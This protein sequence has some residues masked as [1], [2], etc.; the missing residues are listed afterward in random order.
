MRVLSASSLGALTS[1]ALLLTTGL[2]AAAATSAHATTGTATTG[3]AALG[4]AGAPGAPDR[5]PR[6]PGAGSTQSLP[7]TSLTPSDRGPRTGADGALGLAPRTVKPFSLLGVVWED[8]DA[9]LTG[10]VQVRTRTAGTDRWSPWRELD[11]HSGDAPDHGREEQTGGAARGATAPLWVGPSDGVQVR[12]ERAADA[13]RTDGT[14][15]TDSAAEGAA[16]AGAATGAEAGA[17]PGALPEGLRLELVDPGDTKA[18]SGAAE[19]GGETGGAVIPPLT[20]TETDAEAAARGLGIEFAEGGKH[21]GPRPGIVTR[22]GWGANER[23]RESGYAYGKTVRAAFVHHTAMG[24]DYRCSQAPSIIRSIYRYHVKSSGWRDIGYNFLVDKCGKIYEGR[25]GGVTEPVQGAHTYG[26]NTNT[27][28]V[29]VLGS[30]GKSKPSKKALDGVAKLTAWKLGLYGVNARGK[31]TMTSGGGKYAKG[32][33]VRMNTISGHRD[34][35]NTECP[36]ARLY[37]RLDT[38]RATAGRLQ[39][40]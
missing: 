20:R 30:F 34:G 13:A 37:E 14:A 25:A 23:L 35:F 3:T 5:A 18:A 6:M 40:R 7:L 33:R 8:A 31:T 17:A 2:P 12:V 11:T 24:N 10:R 28:G 29:A 39:G 27:M 26:F 36:G 16:H 19:P 21:V 1:A 22:S 38:I 4:T 32:K 9:E 15:R